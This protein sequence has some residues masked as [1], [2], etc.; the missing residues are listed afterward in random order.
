ML[1]RNYLDNGVADGPECRT[2]SMT[3]HPNREV[4]MMR[5]TPFMSPGGSLGGGMV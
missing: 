4:E 5:A 1:A 2:G 3:S